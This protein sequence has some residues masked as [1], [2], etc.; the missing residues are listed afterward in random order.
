[1][2]IQFQYN[3]L[4]VDLGEIAELEE[5][6]S[7]GD[8][9]TDRVFAEEEGDA[10]DLTRNFER[11]VVVENL[12]VVPEEK[13][14]KLRGVIEKIFSMTGTIQEGGLFIPVGADGNLKG[15]A[16]IAYE[17]AE[18]AAQ[19][20][21]AMKD[22]FALD[23]KHTLK[24][25][26]YTQLKTW[27]EW[28]ETYQ[29]PV[30]PTYNAGAQLDSWLLHP[31]QRDQYVVRH[32]NNT[33]ICWVESPAMNGVGTLVYDGER[34]RANGKIW[35]EMYTAWSP[36]GSYLTT[37]HRQGI[38]I[39]GGDQFERQGRFE[40][41]DVQHVSFSP[42]EKFCFTWNGKDDDRDP[43]A[44]I[45]WDVRTKREVRAFKVS[46][47]PKGEPAEWPIMKWSADDQFFARMIEDGVS[48]FESAT[49]K[50]ADK[51]PI[52]TKGVV[53]FE[54]SK[55]E[56]IFA[57]WAPEADTD[58]PAR[59]ALVDAVSR[60]EVRSKNL[61]SVREVKLHWQ[62]NGD[63]LCAQVLRHSRT[64]RTT[65][66]NLEIIRM[67]DPNYPIET[68]EMKDMIEAFAWEPTRERF[69]II[70]G[71]NQHRLNVSFYTMGAVRGGGKMEKLYTVDNKKVA[72]LHWSPI[73]NAIVLA[74][75]SINNTLEFWDVDEKMST[76]TEEHFMCNDVLWDP[77]GRMVVTVATQ[78]MFGSVSMRYQLENSFNLWSFQ[79]ALLRKENLTSF[80]QVR[81][82]HSTAGRQQ[83]RGESGQG[84]QV[85]LVGRE[86]QR[87]KQPRAQ[88]PTASKRA[89]CC[90]YRSVVTAT[91]WDSQPLIVKTA[92]RV[93]AWQTGYAPHIAHRAVLA[94]GRAGTRLSRCVVGEEERE[95]RERLTACFGKNK[96]T[97]P[98]WAHPKTH[99]HSSR[100]AL[101]PRRRSPTRTSRTCSA[102]STL[103]SS[104][105]A[106]RT[107]SA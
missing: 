19:V 75:G 13:L 26:K 15:F 14:E 72:A 94:G 29:K 8:V 20:L 38:A 47:G 2:P 17:T 34:E 1:M 59:V 11:V 55:S 44:L 48:V 9:D 101:A 25:F 84:A 3:D 40:H 103:L 54:W 43:R 63:F 18:A 12:P 92:M 81:S 39:W 58:N 67:R 85:A 65:F 73:G 31:A 42:N 46:R 76:A 91:S 35:C 93:Q 82:R 5:F 74:G 56:P 66:T 45:C 57:Y 60:T 68:L 78:P 32:G 61:F 106:R 80:Y 99:A 27:A 52:K 107:G 49:G 28:P 98:L 83:R 97:D 16:F 30:L 53:A 4:E 95:K 21:K 102:P 87:N 88:Q 86:K 23:R 64:G 6:V 70:H 10:A 77:S 50:L 71:E 7:D 24:V 22:G 36:L 79:G 41:L 69:A 89:S 100:G 96:S 62:N 37:F 33:E 105:S 51:K 104:A 90:W